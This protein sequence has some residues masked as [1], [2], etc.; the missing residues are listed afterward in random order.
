M[1]GTSLV[2]AG[3]VVL[4]L[5]S[6]TPLWWSGLQDP[7]SAVFPNPT[8]IFRGA[9][10]LVLGALLYGW[11]AEHPRA[12]SDFRAVMARWRVDRRAL[13]L[14]VA[15]AGWYVAL[16][17]LFQLGSHG[18]LASAFLLGALLFASVAI[19]GAG[20]GLPALFNRWELLGLSLTVVAAFILYVHDAQNWFY[21]WI[22]DEAAFFYNARQIAQ[23]GPVD[24][25]SQYGVYNTHPVLDSAYQAATIRLFGATAFGWRVSCAL[26]TALA[27]FPLYLLGRLTFSRIAAIIAVGLYVPAQVL[28]AYAHIGYNQP[29][30]LFPLLASLALFLAGRLQRVPLYLFLSGVFGGLC[31]YTLSVARPAVGLIMLGLLVYRPRTWREA[32]H[33]LAFI[34]GGFTLVLLPFVLD[35][36]TGFITVLADQSRLGD[37]NLVPLGI[38]LPQNT[39]RSLF[40][41]IYSAGADNHYVVGALWDTVSAAFLVFGLG[42]L[43][44]WR[45]AASWFLLACYWIMLLINGPTYYALQLNTTRLYIVAPFAALIA[46]IGAAS[47][48]DRARRLAP[49]PGL[50]RV[51]VPLGI[52]SLIVAVTLLNL[53]TFYR[54]VPTTIFSTNQALEIMILQQH[55]RALVVETGNF[56]TTPIEAMAQA[57]GVNSR[58]VVPGGPLPDAVRRARATGRPVIVLS[59]APLPRRGL[60]PGR[61]T[62][63]KDPGHHTT[64]YATYVGQG[65]P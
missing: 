13:V 1:A 45:S 24:L 37:S 2:I 5:P 44:T 25:F 6:S 51:L 42:F 7:L 16:L 31:W 17:D 9:I 23:G 11:S 39:T 20:P 38:R 65:S 59:T 40:A 49:W 61:Q 48:L 50:R 57:Y 15:A 34:L 53:Y 56:A 41:Y 18:Y 54:V 14:A 43:V 60:I 22:G 30:A 19:A 46:A 47:L 36:G 12:P 58:I 10:L 3:L 55:P 32:W 26:A 8:N 21:S 27:I 29:D 4:R 33:D 28:V 63:V 62:I 64:I 52:A 35:N